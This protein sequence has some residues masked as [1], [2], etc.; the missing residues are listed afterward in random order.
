[1]ELRI[2]VQDTL[3]LQETGREE[4]KQEG[5]SHSSNRNLLKVGRDANGIQDGLLRRRY[6]ITDSELVGFAL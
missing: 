1:M 4:H 5:L 6:I 3:S 2:I